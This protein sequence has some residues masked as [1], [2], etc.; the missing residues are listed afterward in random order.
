MVP[1][2]INSFTLQVP[3]GGRANTYRSQVTEYTL[4][5]ETH[6]PHGSA[7]A[8]P[9]SEESPNGAQEEVHSILFPII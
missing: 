4:S 6:L 7:Q 9:R 3:K 2:S 5:R 8:N 1:T